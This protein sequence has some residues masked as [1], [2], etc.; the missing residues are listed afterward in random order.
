MGSA[1]ELRALGVEFY[2]TQGTAEFMSQLGFEP[3]VLKWPLDEG[4]PNALDYIKEGKIGLVI[5]IPKDYHKE[6]LTNDYLIR[7][8]AVD[9][10]VPLITNLQLAQRLV[11]SLCNVPLDKLEVLSWRKY[12][13]G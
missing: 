7:R 5:N 2:A 6:E 9:Y 4:S 11:E 1:S 10:G 3:T 12:G 13:G 8:T